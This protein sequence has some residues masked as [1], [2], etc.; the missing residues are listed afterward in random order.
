MKYL[1]F[2]A[3]IQDIWLFSYLFTRLNS[4]KIVYK[5]SG[6]VTSPHHYIKFFEQISSD[7]F[8]FTGL[9]DEK[10]IKEVDNCDYFITKECL[11]FVEDGPYS[12]KIIGIS[13]VGETIAKTH[14]LSSAR[15]PNPKKI[16]YGCENFYIEKQLKEFYD[17]LKFKTKP[18]SPKYYFLNNSSREDI[19]KI[20]GLDSKKKYF[21]IFSNPNV[22]LDKRVLK[23]FDHIRE[24]GSSLGYECIIKN[25]MKYGDYLR[26]SIDHSFFFDGSPILYHP[27]IML[28][29]VSE[30]SIGFATSASV[31][32]EAIGSR[33]ISF[34]RHEIEDRDTIFNSIF[35]IGNGYRWAQSENTFNICTTSTLESIVNE[36]DK[37]IRKSKCRDFSNKFEEDSFLQSLE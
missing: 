24:L 4:F 14:D 37:F 20:L 13:W 28:Q 22:N 10:F 9:D 27:G 11:P 19:C 1:F 16:V 33:F 21:T 26:N 2:I 15:P 32:S 35:E 18:T 25:K 29:S 5:K 34:W 12:K 6:K 30:F 31:E 7:V 23:I 36:L 3:D 17:Y 8:R